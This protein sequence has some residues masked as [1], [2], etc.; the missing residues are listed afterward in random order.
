[1]NQ[2]SWDTTSYLQ[3]DTRELRRLT[4]LR[5]RLLPLPRSRWS[6]LS[7]HRSGNGPLRRGLLRASY[8]GAMPQLPQ[9]KAVLFD[10][11]QTLFSLAPVGERM[12]EA[13]LTKEQDL[14][15][16]PTLPLDEPMSHIRLRLQ[17]DA[18]QPR[19]RR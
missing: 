17:S 16:C 5:T 19:S 3:L 6:F 15:V 14:Q 7:Q 9:P 18:V 13:G 1:L 11:N 4:A 12:R 8:I 10:V 2:E